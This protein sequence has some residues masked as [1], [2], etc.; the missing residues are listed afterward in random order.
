MGRL[1]GTMNRTL[2]LLGEQ[3]QAILARLDSIESE[4][5]RL[6]SFS[7]LLALLEDEVAAHFRIEEEA[8]FPFLDGHADLRRGPLVVVDAEHSAF[9]DLVLDLRDAIRVADIE[10]QRVCAVTIIRFLRGHITK[11]D[12]VLFPMAE[13]CLSERERAEIDEAARDAGAF[14]LVVGR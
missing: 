13:A 12:Q 1:G 11:E 10:L 5:E 8:L 14:E 2:Q 7:A 9:R 3:H 6:E 4:V